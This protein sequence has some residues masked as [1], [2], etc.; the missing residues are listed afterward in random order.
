[1]TS[2]AP[3]FLDQPYLLSNPPLRRAKVAAAL[4]DRLGVTHL[5]SF[6]HS[7]DHRSERTGPHRVPMVRVDTCVGVR[8]RGTYVTRA[9][10]EEAEAPPLLQSLHMLRA[11]G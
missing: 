2:L 1:M 7:D 8:G 10:P 6:I 3:H 11:K 5:H 4:W 9:G